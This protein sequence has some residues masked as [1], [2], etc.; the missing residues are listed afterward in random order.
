METKIKNNIT[1]SHYRKERLCTYKKHINS[2]N[3]ENYKMLIKEIK[4]DL[5]RWKDI[6]SS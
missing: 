5:S 3:A 6:M 4:E 2:L 1:Y